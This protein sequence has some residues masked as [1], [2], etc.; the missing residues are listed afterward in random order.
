M[1]GKPG[2]FIGRLPCRQCCHYRP[3]FAKAVGTL[4]KV[5][6]LESSELSVISCCDGDF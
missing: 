5:R 2:P 3:T 4:K 1:L 6:L